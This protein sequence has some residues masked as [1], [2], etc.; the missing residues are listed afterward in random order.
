MLLE[1]EREQLLAK[2]I[3]SKQK[4]LYELSN[5]AKRVGP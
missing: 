4:I 2:W 1:M 5:Y 3:E